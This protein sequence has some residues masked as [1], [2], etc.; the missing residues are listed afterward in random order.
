[1][2]AL[3]FGLAVTFVLPL[4]ATAAFAQTSSVAGRVTD[5]DRAVVMEAD[6]TLTLIDSGIGRNS[7]SATRRVSGS[8]C[9][10]TGYSSTRRSSKS[11]S[12]T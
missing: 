2:K 12:G 3:R 9:C 1:M 10:G 5:P 8:V 7:A 11:P 6:V 4:L